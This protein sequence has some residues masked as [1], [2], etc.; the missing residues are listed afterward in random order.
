MVYIVQ[1]LAAILVG[2]SVASL[3]NTR[4]T[5]VVIGSIIAIVLAVGT[6]MTK[7]WWILWAGTAAFIIGQM[8]H[9]DN[10]SRLA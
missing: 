5:F 7:S 10:F 8:F 2:I 9:R 6:F 1:I 4:S 3:I